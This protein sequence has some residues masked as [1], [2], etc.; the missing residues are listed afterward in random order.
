M[1]NEKAL[2]AFMGK[3]AEAHALLG[4]LQAHVD[5]HM[6]YSPDD[7]NYGHVGSAGWLVEKLTELTDW[8]YKC[9]EHAE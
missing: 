7:I 8:A 5:E 6:G 3:I 2:Q 9:G 1:N 4:E